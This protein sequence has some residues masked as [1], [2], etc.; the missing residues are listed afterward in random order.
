M[1]F[2]IFHHNSGKSLI[3]ALAFPVLFHFEERGRKTQPQI[4][5]KPHKTQPPTTFSHTGFSFRSVLVPELALNDQGQQKLEA[6][7]FISIR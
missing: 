2:A 4:P 1:I 6:A 5:N 3:P 7:V